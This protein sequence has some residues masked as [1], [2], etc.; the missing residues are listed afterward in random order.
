[1]SPTTSYKSNPSSLDLDGFPLEAIA[2]EGE[3]DK[4][5]PASPG[6]TALL[7]NPILMGSGSSQPQ[8]RTSS[9]LETKP[10]RPALRRSFSMSGNWPVMAAGSFKRPATPVR[11]G[12]V[13][14]SMT[15]SVSTG[16]VADPQEENRKLL[17]D[18]KENP[19]VLPDGSK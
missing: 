12:P 2:E 6:F 11:L 10:R 14:R 1:M 9:E 8:P 5:V 15:R 13:T 19:D 17:M 4:K 18:L 7:T 16:L 3:E